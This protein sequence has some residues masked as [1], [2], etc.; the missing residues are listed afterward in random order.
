MVRKAR[1]EFAGAIYHVLDRGDRREGIFRDDA[2]RQEKGVMVQNS[3]AEYLGVTRTRNSQ[4]EVT[5]YVYYPA[6]AGGGNAGRLQEIR[7]PGNFLLSSFKYDVVGRV[8]ETTGADGY[9]LRH[10]YD[11]LDRPVRTVFPDGSYE[12][13]IYHRL[14]AEWQRDR[15]GRSGKEGSVWNGANLRRI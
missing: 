6:N 1:V 12:Q 4:Q 11:A 14:D 9:T 15:Q 10:Y 8:A 2:D 5:A 7:G 13:T 3:T